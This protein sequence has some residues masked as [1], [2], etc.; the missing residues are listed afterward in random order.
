MVIV[1]CRDGRAAYYHVSPEYARGVHFRVS[2][3][4]PMLQQAKRSQ[5]GRIEL[6]DARIAN[7]IGRSRAKRATLS[8][9]GCVAKIVD[10]KHQTITVYCLVS[11]G[12]ARCKQDGIQR[13]RRTRSATER[14]L[15]VPARG[16]YRLVP[17]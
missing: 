10:A 15:I 2:T 6:A 3:E 11:S 4:R 12:R 14:I 8:A 7:A 17:V 13:L 9:D 16:K 5:L 1:S